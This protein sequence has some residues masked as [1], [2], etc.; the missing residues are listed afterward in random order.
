MK[1]Y[2]AL[3]VLASRTLGVDVKFGSGGTNVYQ[4]NTE[5]ARR[6]FYFPYNSPLLS[7]QTTTCQGNNEI[8]T[9]NIYSGHSNVEGKNGILHDRPVYYSDGRTAFRVPGWMK[10]NLMLQKLERIDNP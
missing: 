3:A 7:E 9:G 4:Y 8:C 6:P 5:E 2:T 10:D 1:L